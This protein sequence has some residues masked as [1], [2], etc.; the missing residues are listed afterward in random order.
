MFSKPIL[1][2]RNKILMGATYSI[3]L[4]RLDQAMAG[5]SRPSI[6]IM[7][8]VGYWVHRILKVSLKAVRRHGLRNASLKLMFS[9]ARHLPQISSKLKEETEKTRAS[10]EHSLLKET[11][12]EVK[13]IRLPS[14]GTSASEL[15]TQLRSW[16]SKENKTWQSGQVSGAV[17]HGGDE[18][19]ELNGEVFKLFS[20]ANP[21]HPDLFPYTRKMEA[22]VIAMV[23]NMF[24]G[25]SLPDAGGSLTSGGTESILLAC[26]AYRDMARAERGIYEPQM[27]VPV[28]IHAAF[29]KAAHYFD[30]ELIPVPVDP[31]TFQCD[32]AAVKRNI[33]R[34]TILI[35]GSAPC[36]A[37]GV[38]D[39]IERLAEIA[40]KRNI[41][42][43]SDCCLG[44]F[45]LSC[46]E[47][48]GRKLPPYDFRVE[49][50]TSIST[51][52]HKF[53]FTPKGTS[54][55][56]YRSNKLRQYQYFV[57]PDW[58]GGIYAT[59]T[60]AGSRSGALSA[61]S[62]AT[63]MHFGEDGY[64]KAAKE[65]LDV[66]DRIK[67]GIRSNP[68][69]KLH[70]IP[71]LTVVAFSTTEASGV[72]IYQ[73]GEAMSRKG[74]NLNSLQHPA[75]IHICCTYLLKGKGE[76]FLQD[77]CSSIQDIHENPDD[78]SDGAVAMYGM[79]ESLPDTSVLGDMA[80]LY[81]DT[82]YKP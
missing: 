5:W 11:A 79:A 9:I 64:L 37:Q 65:I 1:L 66:S 43:H 45:M 78:F 77:L 2:K 39:P 35:A 18:L 68:D 46:W 15:L 31:V 82:L 63:M 71:E 75:S 49:G 52:P 13:N 70:G 27:I 81:I 34:N 7:I 12:G 76:K 32:I 67:E 53:G 59:A 62:W 17:Y 73:V 41:G 29:E 50:V 23:L 44:S 6:V 74:W 42:F 61:C 40:R 24:H 28:T 25:T 4:S 47:K 10:L 57:S 72:N 8:V 21:L 48:M 26:K 51:D 33:T 60:L 14:N 56:M 36:F 38:F 80:M 55:V 54:I 3:L 19:T 69:L 16:N 22:E 58:T 30:I 20:V